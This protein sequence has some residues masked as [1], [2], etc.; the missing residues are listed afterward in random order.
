MLTCLEFGEA[1]FEVLK[2]TMCIFQSLDWI[3]CQ[4]LN[5]FIKGMKQGMVLQSEVVIRHWAVNLVVVA[6]D[7]FVKHVLVFL[8]LLF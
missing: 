4:R 6:A 7:N 1:L 5:S 3:D 2:M 8:I